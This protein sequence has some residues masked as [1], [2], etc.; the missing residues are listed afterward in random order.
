M[1]KQNS[2]D[3]EVS[4]SVSTVRPQAESAGGLTKIVVYIYIESNRINL[5]RI[6]QMCLME[7]YY[8][9]VVPRQLKVGDPEQ[10]HCISLSECFGERACVVGNPTL[11][12]FVINGNR[13]RNLPGAA[14][15]VAFLSHLFQCH[16][17]TLKEASKEAVMNKLERKGAGCCCSF[18]ISG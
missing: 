4:S 2:K 18:W 10:P 11:P 16:P 3:V 17:L 13:L 12:P 5:N 9:Q 6:I 7:K 14:A 1:N 8:F 15:E